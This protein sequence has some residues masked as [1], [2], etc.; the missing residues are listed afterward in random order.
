MVA[1]F[2]TPK[3]HPIDYKVANFGQDE[4]IKTTLGNISQSETDLKHKLS[5]VAK[6]DRPA[7][8]P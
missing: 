8:H 3:G 4:N 5:F 2:K 1:S 7:P 6:K